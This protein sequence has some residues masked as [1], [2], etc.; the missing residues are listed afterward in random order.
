[1]T[2]GGF[3]STFGTIAGLAPGTIIYQY[4]GGESL[5]LLT[6]AGG[7]AIDV[8]DTGEPT[9]LS[10]PG[11]GRVGAPNFIAA[12]DLGS[13]QG[14][15]G[16]LSMENPHS[17]NTITAVDDSG[18]TTALRAVTLGTFTPKQDT[19]LEAILEAMAPS[20]NQLRV[21]RYEKPHSGDRQCRQYDRRPRDR[22]AHFAGRAASGHPR[23]SRAPSR[24][25][26]AAACRGIQGV[27]SIENP[28]AANTITV[29][30]STD[31][32]AR[33]VTLGSFANPGDSEGN[34]DPWGY[35]QGLAPANINY[36]CADTGSIAVDG[37]TGKDTYKVLATGATT[38]LNTGSG[39]DAVKLGDAGSLLGIQA[40]LSVIG[41]GGNVTL[42]VDDHSSTAAQ[43]YNV[44]YA[45][46]LYVRP[47]SS[48]I[49][50]SGVGTLVLNG[51]K[52]GSTYNIESTAALHRL[53]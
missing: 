53:P 20:T 52:G 45:T 42:S 5:D 19:R 28:N 17:L 18:D 51:S 31:N 15:A 13:V 6:S 12:I 23:L 43:T 50:Y 24:S 9:S 27:L 36:E 2:L 16:T 40:S 49:T 39:N 30:D 22:R 21:C 41:Q 48:G 14:I 11:I 33:T 29:D 32:K 34:S 1:M 8:L 46:V 38:Y 10:E 44:N 35:I 37:G 47:D 26:A 7:S 3:G 25:V 4:S